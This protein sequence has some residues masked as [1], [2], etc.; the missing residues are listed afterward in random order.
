MKY[1][2][3]QHEP[4]IVGAV[5]KEVNCDCAGLK[6]IAY[7]HVRLGVYH[8]AENDCNVYEIELS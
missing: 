6:S 2:I 3:W 4:V 5:S 8:T 1:E 7:Y